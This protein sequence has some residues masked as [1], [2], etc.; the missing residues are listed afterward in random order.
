MAPR[1]AL[2]IHALRVVARRLLAVDIHEFELASDDGQPLPAYTPGAHLLV[3]VPNGLVR[4]YS[5]CGAPAKQDRYVIAVKREAG[6]RG[7]SISLVDGVRVGDALKVSEPRNAFPLIERPG[8][9]LFI[10]GGIGITPL[11]SMA[12]YLQTG[13]D[14]PFRLIY[15]TRSPETT[16][17]ADELSS[18]SFQGKAVVHHDGGDPSRVFDLWSF[19]ER[20]K[21]QVYCCGPHSLM[22]A[23][24]AM[25][26]H[27]PT[28]AIH[29]EDFKGTSTSRQDDTAFSVR[30]ARSGGTVMVPA[31]V[32][33]LE[34]LR[35]HGLSV[36]SSCES[37]TCGCCLTGL[38]EGEPD[39]RD[40]V[41][42]EEE[43]KGCIA[44][45]VSRARSAELVLDL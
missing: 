12:R 22:E 1:P 43:R 3:E 8:G 27:W 23:V 19:L 33:L 11:L 45:C 21:G 4:S 36:L 34:A 42:S 32:T 29:F 41:L 13:G 37:G 18:S 6:G 35:E 31:G 30:L 10:A 7:G 15:L 40:L 14:T 24:S 26:G 25:T 20:P 16:A 2:G 17:F 39:H 5:L 9:Y 44:V 28:S 38:L